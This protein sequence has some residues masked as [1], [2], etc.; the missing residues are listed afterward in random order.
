MLQQ[1]RLEGTN[2]LLVGGINLMVFHCPMLEIIHPFCMVLDKKDTVIVLVV[3][4]TILRQDVKTESKVKRIRIHIISSL[5]LTS[6]IYEWENGKNNSK[7]Q[8][9]EKVAKTISAHNLFPMTITI[10]HK[11]NRFT[12][13]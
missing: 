8:A 9:R 7:E 2:N 1:E 6:H 12:Y 13:Y 5:Y 11:P 4:P 10:F 3:N